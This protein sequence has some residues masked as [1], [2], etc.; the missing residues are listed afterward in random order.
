MIINVL[1]VPVGYELNKKLIFLEK[2]SIPMPIESTCIYHCGIVLVII[3]TCIF[4]ID[5]N[6]ILAISFG[7]RTEC[8][9]CYIHVYTDNKM[10]SFFV[11]ICFENQSD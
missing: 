4:C 8:A 3:A 1:Y 10:I 9:G 6:K 2:L 7:A 11:A 5:Q